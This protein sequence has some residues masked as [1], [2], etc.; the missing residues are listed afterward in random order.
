MVSLELHVKDCE[1]FPPLFVWHTFA[2]ESVP[3]ENSL[4]LV[5]A[6]REAFPR[7]PM[8]CHFY[9]KGRHGLSLATE[10]TDVGDGSAIEPRAARW[11]EAAIDWLKD[12]KSFHRQK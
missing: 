12:C 10:R 11:V 6:V 2:D 1:S 7:L 3:I 8:E 4:L 5:S 9:E